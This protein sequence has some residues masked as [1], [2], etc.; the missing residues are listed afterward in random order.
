MLKMASIMNGH[1]DREKLAFGPRGKR[2]ENF[3]NIFASG[4]K[5]FG[6]FRVGGVVAEQVA[7]FLDRGTAAGRVGYDGFDI[8]LF[9]CVDRLSRQL[10]RLGFLTCMDIDRAT[11]W[12][13]R[14]CNHLA[15]F[16]GKD[17][18]RRSVNLR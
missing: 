11:A 12:L 6:A 8:G 10:L 17:A 4:S 16:G 7:I 18:R 2:A 3:A 5:T 15:A 9:K 14:W 1:A 13:F